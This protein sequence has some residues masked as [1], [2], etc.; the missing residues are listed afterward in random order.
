MAE[1]KSVAVGDI[2]PLN[3]GKIIRDLDFTENNI[4]K[5][6]EA[7][8]LDNDAGKTLPFQQQALLATKGIHPSAPQTAQ[9]SY[10]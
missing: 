9:E 5:G 10:R 1:R 3:R 4:A 7:L 8:V 2:V 6:I